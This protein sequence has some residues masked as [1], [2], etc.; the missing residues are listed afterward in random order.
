MR[1]GSRVE[2]LVIVFVVEKLQHFKELYLEREHLGKKARSKIL[3]G[4]KI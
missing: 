1:I 3:T 2:S 4:Y